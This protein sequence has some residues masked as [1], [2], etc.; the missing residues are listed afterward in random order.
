MEAK[1]KLEALLKLMPDSGNLIRGLVDRLEEEAYKRGFDYARETL[2]SA[3][4]NKTLENILNFLRAWAED[5]VF[6]RTWLEA[7]ISNQLRHFER[8]VKQE[9]AE[10][11]CQMIDDIEVKNQGDTVTLEEW[12]MFKRI[13]NTIRDK[14]MPEGYQAAK[15]VGTPT[16][17]ETGTDVSTK[18]CKKELKEKIEKKYGRGGAQ[19]DGYN[20]ALDDV[21]MLLSGEKG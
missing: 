11:I 5:P 8:E 17:P 15:D 10:N 14:Y 9:I 18:D 7:Q 21:L 12:K 1:Q 3:S 13:R 2:P 19:M 20:E 4:M 16:K 6:N